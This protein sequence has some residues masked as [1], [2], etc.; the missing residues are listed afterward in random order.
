MAKGVQVLSYDLIKDLTNKHKIDK[1]LSIVKSGDVVMLEGR[2][3]REIEN[4]LITSALQS[5]SGKFT[6]I[7]V[8]FLD[9]KT[10]KTILGK[11]K[12]KVLKLIAKD[13]IGI[14]VIGP[15]KIIKE[16]KMDPKKL[17]ILFK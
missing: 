7:E 2:L 17:E 3:S 1:I 13:R 9:S 11:L 6:G 12:L 8:A 16:I 10:E 14:S 4:E 5:V 15:S